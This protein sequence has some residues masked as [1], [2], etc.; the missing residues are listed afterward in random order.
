MLE[1]GYCSSTYLVFFI[2]WKEDETSY[3][4]KVFP[5]TLTGRKDFAYE[6]SKHDLI[7]FGTSALKAL[8][9]SDEGIII[10]H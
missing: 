9:C 10:V 6:K 8:E 5:N 1:K 3:A 7:S 2:K 4:I